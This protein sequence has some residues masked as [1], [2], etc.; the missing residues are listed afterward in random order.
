M[1]MPQNL[2]SFMQMK[3]QA[4]G[5]EERTGKAGD[6]VVSGKLS[7]EEVEHL[8]RTC[9]SLFN[10]VGIVE[11]RAPED[12]GKFRVIIPRDAITQV[13]TPPTSNIASVGV[14]SVRQTAVQPHP[15]EAG[16]RELAR[17]S[18][19]IENQLSF[20]SRVPNRFQ[21]T[22]RG[23]RCPD[24]T[25]LIDPT[26][27][28]SYQVHANRV[29]LAGINMICS[30]APIPD[31][32][33]EFWRA[34]FGN[35]YMILD[36]TNKSDR[37]DKQVA[38]YF[39]HEVGD[40]LHKG[41]ISVLCVGEEKSV[42]GEKKLKLHTYLVKEKQGTTVQE[43]PIT[44]LHYRGWPDSSSIT[45]KDLITIVNQIRSQR[46]AL[47]DTPLWI[48]CR[49]GVGRTGTVA[50]ALALAQMKSEGRLTEKNYA[51]EIDNLILRGRSQRDI[52]FVQSVNQYQLLHDFA[53]AIL[54][55]AH[56]PS[57]AAIEPSLKEAK[58]NLYRKIETKVE[59]VPTLREPITAAGGVQKALEKLFEEI[60]S[61]STPGETEPEFLKKVEE[62]RRLLAQTIV[63]VRDTI[64]VDPSNV[65]E[66]K[67][68]DS[69]KFEL[70]KG[71]RQLEM[72]SDMKKRPVP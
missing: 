43:K 63:F 67:V 36:L 32:E 42:A 68:Y 49:A 59:D 39:P 28:E 25:Q 34:V 4:S 9:N 41:P 58:E 6:Q 51:Q 62:L 17:Q 13:F 64:E 44:R 29:E 54:A 20:T 2:P 21:E 26:T 15:L 45:T 61:L 8:A 23:T 31:S 16:F 47:G 5:W 7:R 70:L 24:A 56:L 72:L 71:S 52:L 19:Q 66:K 40:Q 10:R 69:L 14:A 12:K 55:L 3:T 46:Q 1:G 65:E 22:D 60:E 48:H 35:T 18:R 53:Q 27:E 38:R 57:E 30:Q 50:V 11:C 33:I 37:I